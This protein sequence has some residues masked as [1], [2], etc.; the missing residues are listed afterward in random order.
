MWNKSQ[1]AKSSSRPVRNDNSRLRS[2]QEYYVSIGV[3][4]AGVPHVVADSPY[5]AIVP[6][7]YLP[8][9][10]RFRFSIPKER[11]GNSNLTTEP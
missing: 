5:Q 7:P 4:L 1:R 10:C 9:Q 2:Y 6:R 3:G 8:R 11:P